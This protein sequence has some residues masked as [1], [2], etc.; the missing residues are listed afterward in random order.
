TGEAN[1]YVGKG[2]CGGELILRPAGAARRA[3][4]RNLILGNV[5]LYGAT[6]GRLFAAGVAGERFG[7]RNSGASAVVEGVGDHA[8]E[9]M[10]GG[11]IVILGETGSNF[12]AGMTGGT[13]FVFDESDT[14]TE[15][16]NDEFVACRRLDDV[17][18]AILR[19]LLETHVERTQSVHAAAL[20]AQWD[21]T[22][23]RFWKVEPKP[24]TA[25][26]KTEQSAQAARLV[27]RSA[28]AAPIDAAPDV[29]PDVARP[30]ENT[31]LAADSGEAGQ[32]EA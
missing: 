16:A 3:P 26:V 32:L 5:A 8:C 9:Y 15:R 18:A 27:A 29:A 7:V 11:V 20:V 10:T 19:A 14:F 28:S 31:R 25:T 6:S 30:E 23:E 24:S 21:T 12:G 4:H 22:R 2:L 1:D 13:A 17:D